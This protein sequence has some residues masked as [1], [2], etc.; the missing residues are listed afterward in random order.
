VPFTAISLGQATIDLAAR[1]GDPGFVRWTQS[2]LAD[3]IRSSLRE[4]NAISGHFRSAA[5]FNTTANTPFVD[6]SVAVPSLLGRTVTDRDLVATI[7]AHLLE[8]VTPTSWSGTAQFTLADVVQAIQRR[9]DQFLMDSGLVLTRTTPSVG[10]TM[11]GRI[12]LDE[13]II[14]VRRVAFTNS[15]GTT[16]LNRED[17]WAF[18]HWATHWETSRI[19]LRL[20]GER[21]AAADDAVGTAAL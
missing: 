14:T 2:E 9:R 5:V 19:A 6:L 17:V 13:S 8:P 3:L 4:F 15:D 20:L 11:G 18:N 10:P 1:L 7:Q 12:Q 21:D 16:P